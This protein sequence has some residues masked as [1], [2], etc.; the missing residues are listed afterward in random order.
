MIDTPSVDW[1]A[2]SPT[3][4]LLAAAGVALLSALLPA[5]MRKA[6]RRYRG[7]RRLRRRGRPRRLVFDESSTPE[8]LLEGT[9]VRDQLAAHGAGDPRRD[10][11]GRRARVLG[12]AP[13]REPRRVLRAPRD[14]RRRDGVLRRRREPHDALPRARVVLAVPVHPRRHRLR[15]RD[16]ARGGPQVPHRRAASARPCCSSAR[17]SSTERRRS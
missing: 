1:L 14:G 15:A 2:L 11:R 12:R 9:M 3:I 17:R 6:G 8:V 13:A 10:R 7:V 4:A 5:W 16:V